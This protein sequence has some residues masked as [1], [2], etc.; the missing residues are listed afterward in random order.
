MSDKYHGKVI[1]FENNKAF[2]DKL[3]RRRDFID[4]SLSRDA[5]IK[6]GDP[7][8][9]LPND[10]LEQHSR[11]NLDQSNTLSYKLILFGIIPDGS[12]VAVVIEN[13]KPFFDIRTPKAIKPDMFE[14][15]IVGTL[16]ANQIYAA[17]TEVIK[18]YPF[19]YFQERESDYIRLYFNSLHQRNKAIR[20]V[21]DHDFEYV[22][23]DAVSQRV[24]LETASDDTS[25]HWRKVSREYKFRLCA[26]NIV[27]NYK[28]DTG[29]FTKSQSVRYTFRID[30]SGIED[31]SNKIDIQSDPKKYAH[32]L[33]DRSMIGVWDTETD[34]VNTSGSAPLPENVFDE[35]D[36]PTDVLRMMSNVFYWYYDKTPLVQVNFTDLVCPAIPDCLVVICQDQ[37]EIIKCQ[38]LLVELMAPEFYAG[39]NDGLYDWPFVMERAEE[40]DKKKKTQLITFMKRHMAAIPYND[41]TSQYS[42]IGRSKNCIKLEA[43]TN[44]DNHFFT[45]PGTICFDV[46]TIFRQLY[47]TAEKSSLNFFL[48]MNK[49]GSKEDMPYLV[50]FQIFKLVRR[51]AK[52]GM[53]F[54]QIVEFVETEIREH[55]AEHRLFPDEARGVYSIN[56]TLRE[57]LDL[58]AQVSNVVTYCNTDARR[59]Q[60]LLNVRMIIPDK[61]EVSN[62]SYMSM[63]DALFYAGGVKVRNLVISEGIKPEWN[64]TFTNRTARGKDPRKYPGAYV[65]PP[66]KGLYRDHKAVKKLRR[67]DTGAVNNDTDDRTDRPCAGLDFSSLYPSLIMTYNLSPEKVIVNPE[68]KSYLESRLDC[69]GKQYKFMEIQ[70]GYG[71]SGQREEDKE[72]IHGWFVQHHPIPNPGAK[73]FER[74]EGM[75]LYP[76]ILKNLFDLRSGIKKRMEYYQK[77]KEFLDKVFESRKHLQSESL[78][79]QFKYIRLMLGNE[80]EKR[81]ADYEANKKNFYKFRIFEIEDITKFFNAEVFSSQDNIAV[82]YENICF[83]ANYF[84]VKQNALKVFMNTLYGEA[85]NSLSPFFIPHV[86]GA[87]T[88]KGQD[89]IKMVK[90]FVENKSCHVKYGD[91]DSLYPSPP[92]DHFRD[93][94]E[95]YES[96]NIT[97]RDYWSGMIEKT[98]EYL[99]LLA[100]EVGELLYQDNGTRFLKMAYEEVLFPYAFVGKKK[101]IGIQ[102]Q[103]IVNLS[104]CMAECTLDEFMKS[105]SL[106]VRGLETK[107]R[108]SS[109]FLKLVCFE[110]IKEAFCIESTRTLKEIVEFK[111]QEIN[112]REWK[113]DLFMKSARYKLPGKN[114]NGELKRGN[115]SVLRF[116]SRMRQIESEYPD[117]GIRAPEP[118]ERFDYIVAKKHPWVYD[119]RGRKTKLA[120]GDKYEYADSFKNAKYIE[121]LDGLEV[122]MDY[123]VLNE[124]IGQL[125]RFI[126]YHPDYDKFFQDSMYE[127]DDA[128]KVADKNAHTYAKKELQR[129]YNEKYAFTYPDLGKEHKRIFKEVSTVMFDGLSERFGP[130]ARMFHVA[131]KLPES[132][133]GTDV[134]PMDR[135]TLMRRQLRSLL[136]ESAQHEGTKLSAV[137]ISKIKTAKSKFDPFKLYRYYISAPNSVCNI[138]R[139][140]ASEMLSALTQKLDDVLPEFYEAC[141]DHNATMQMLIRRK[142]PDGAS[143]HTI[144]SES[145]VG[146]YNIYVGMV[147]VHRTLAELDVIKQELE[148]MKASS[149]NQLMIP[150]GAIGK[151]L[152]SKRSQSAA[153]A[154]LKKDFA[155][156]LETQT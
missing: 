57:I 45:F 110:I 130:A 122:D 79:D 140:V 72:Q 141:T 120:I 91:T 11:D 150:P 21:A 126:I 108:G 14:Q 148:C 47:P 146:I 44:V 100:V 61:R 82:Q 142:D 71:L 78:D 75:G 62:L 103:G 116:V 77:P 115:I 155:S 106:F 74:F 19:K 15:R 33:K 7:I 43:D 34:S 105:K 1:H 22:S 58:L 26:W 89:N 109:Q 63:R 51:L 13:I 107:K 131:E 123:Y 76:H 127:D 129:V 39:F 154:G 53:G 18:R 4:R 65:V 117:F 64:I 125:S 8:E 152:P 114:S 86:A 24:Q 80:L 149:Y 104:A 27:S 143:G 9:F 94:D 73:T 67:S 99:D 20:Y 16:K 49:L 85:G 147:A 37:T 134:D 84:N 119:I 48:A 118:G 88:V 95:L 112:G 50:M 93:L 6:S 52:P 36:N 17:R 68:F 97:K 151:P 56:L 136:L 128:Y 121:L 42:I 3:P 90:R 132:E 135:S 138:R 144:E 92:E 137:V 38:A 96:G 87:T 30:S 133:P 139:H 102:H 23:D 46:R 60:E 2:L 32:L 28:L 10:V 124:I 153:Q 70:F 59:C 81:K 35:S 55:G 113:T 54:E 41:E 12:K 25:G 101:Y 69:F 98:M 145:V 40:Y 156:W 83:N 111:L 31:L 66:R 29:T 5:V